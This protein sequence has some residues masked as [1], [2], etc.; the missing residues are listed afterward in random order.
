MATQSKRLNLAAARAVEGAALPKIASRKDFEAQLNAL[1]IREKEHTHR[2]D[3]IAADRRR[4]PMVEVNPSTQLAGANGPLT[5][6]DAFENRKLL[7]A[8]YFMWHAGH[9]AK[10]QCQGCTW[11]T[12]HIHELSYFH[13]RDATFAV[14]CQ[15]PY[16]E[17]ARYRDFMGWQMPW[18]SALG[19]L[20]TLLEGRRIGRMHL[21]CYLRDGTNVFETY[22]T[23]SRGV[24]VMDNSYHL[25]DLTV[26]G[27]Q[28]KH[29][30]S[31]SGWPQAYAI[32]E[33]TLDGRPVSQ[34]SRVEVG[35]PDDLGNGRPA[36]H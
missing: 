20:E 2:G 35:I 27:R 22:W 36:L 10:D 18:Y 7:I 23:T 29:E 30:D 9:P 6:L 32:G 11:V 14:F 34:W 28:E 16:D 3:A 15:G 26:Y 5:L 33:L 13:A 8:Y 19:S 25:L 24:E 1:R 21:V 12:S 31:P 4:L 17:S